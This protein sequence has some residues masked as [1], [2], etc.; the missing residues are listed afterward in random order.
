[1]VK[2]TL[3]YDGWYE[4]DVVDEIC[5]Q[6]LQ[7]NVKRS[8][9]GLAMKSTKVGVGLKTCVLTRRRINQWKRWKSRLR[10]AIPH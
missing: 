2:D 10:Y 4:C 1:M 3:Q 5:L 6:I 8:E 9:A 7:P